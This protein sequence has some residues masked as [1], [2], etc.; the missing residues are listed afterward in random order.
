MIKNLIVTDIPNNRESLEKVL[1]VLGDR[2][3]TPENIDSWV[4]HS[5]TAIW[6]HS[7]FYGYLSGDEVPINSTHVYKT[8]EQVTGK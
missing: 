5:Y 4:F 3:W 6:Y 8:F 2:S 1:I 7:K